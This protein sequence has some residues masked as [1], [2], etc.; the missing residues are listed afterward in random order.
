[1][2]KIIFLSSVEMYLLKP[3]IKILETQHEILKQKINN[4]LYSQKENET[5]LKS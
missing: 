2:R 4:F 1:M 5:R 3:H